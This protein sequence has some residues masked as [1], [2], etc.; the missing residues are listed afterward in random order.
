ME[1]VASN[2]K[3]RAQRGGA[4]APFMDNSTLLTA[5]AFYG[6]MRDLSESSG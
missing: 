3:D 2:L 4:V 1:R 6:H 5:L